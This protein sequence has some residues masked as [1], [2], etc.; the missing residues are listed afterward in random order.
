MVDSLRPDQFATGSAIIVSVLNLSAAISFPLV[1][2]I[3]QTGVVWLTSCRGPK[4]LVMGKLLFYVDPK[5][6]T[7][8]ERK[9]GSDSVFR[10]SESPSSS[11]ICWRFMRVFEGVQLFS[12]SQDDDLVDH[13]PF[14]VWLDLTPKRFVPERNQSCHS[15]NHCCH[16]CKGFN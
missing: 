10:V 14:G 2:E 16:N 9:N 12:V 1:G 13:L 4:P 15:G 11:W 8:K 7:C 5:F 6:D 3:T